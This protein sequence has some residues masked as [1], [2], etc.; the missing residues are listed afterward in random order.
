VLEL[1]ERGATVGEGITPSLCHGCFVLKHIFVDQGVISG[2]LDFEHCEGGDPATEVAWCNDYL[3]SMWDGFTGETSI[4]VPV[5]PLITGY[6]RRTDLDDAF[7]ERAQWN[8]QVGFL[9]GLA[10]HGVSDVD[11]AGAMPFLKA[12]FEKRY[13]LSWPTHD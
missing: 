7:W 4:P 12:W 2:V 5:T 11:M 8:Q 1:L 6:R 13:E 3:T 10:Y 9:L